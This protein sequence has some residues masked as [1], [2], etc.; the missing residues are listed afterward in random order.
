MF[1]NHIVR[2]TGNENGHRVV[3]EKYLGSGYVQTGEG[4][5][6]A[7]QR[8]TTSSG[9]VAGPNQPGEV[10]HTPRLNPTGPKGGTE[11]E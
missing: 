8:G 1:A 9:L 4:E 2:I 11:V 10:H 7:G 3:D 6:L 5:E